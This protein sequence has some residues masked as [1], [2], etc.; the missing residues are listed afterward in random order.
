MQVSR[1]TLFQAEG[2]SAGVLR[3]V[4][5][6]YRNSE[7]ATAAGPERGAGESWE[8]RSERY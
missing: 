1:K 5:G 6:A 7:K 8:M 3:W 4:L 2:A